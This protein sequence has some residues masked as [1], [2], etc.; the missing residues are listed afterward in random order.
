MTRYEFLEWFQ[1]HRT[2]NPTLGR[3]GGNGKLGERERREGREVQELRS[4]VGR[5]WSSRMQ[6]R[7]KA[8]PAPPQLALPAPDTNAKKQR[9]RGSRGAKKGTGKSG[10]NNRA[11]TQVGGSSRTGRLRPAQEEGP[12]IYRIVSPEQQRACHLF[13]L[14]ETP[15]RRPEGL[16]QEAC[17]H[18]LRHRGQALQ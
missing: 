1:P 11:C 9:Q 15:V 4:M 7:Q 10:K 16:Q 18:R 2:R 3:A 13:Q 5:L 12:E 14:S 6:P 17:L 8:M